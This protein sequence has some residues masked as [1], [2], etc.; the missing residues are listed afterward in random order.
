M[1]ERHPLKPIR[2]D[3]P[4][5]LGVSM[6]NSAS[7]SACGF[8]RIVAA[9]E[10]VGRVEVRCKAA[11]VEEI[12]VSGNRR[13]VLR[14]GIERQPRA[15]AIAVP[16]KRIERVAHERSKRL[17]LFLRNPAGLN[18]DQPRTE[19]ERQGHDLFDEFDAWLLVFEHV[20]TAPQWTEDC[21]KL[22]V[23]RLEKVTD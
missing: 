11:A 4:C 17:I 8:I 2:A 21:S 18:D 1:A 20:Q 13:T 19:V 15:D 6:S 5:I 14:S 12:E 16:A 9:D 3:R 23:E 10:Q 22:Q 7:Q